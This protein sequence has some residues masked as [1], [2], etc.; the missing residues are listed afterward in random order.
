MAPAMSWSTLAILLMVRQ[1]VPSWR[2]TLAPYLEGDTSMIASRPMDVDNDREWL[3][4]T[5]DNYTFGDA[6][7]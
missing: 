7:F 1:G 6:A 4:Y 2:L 3:R 5:I